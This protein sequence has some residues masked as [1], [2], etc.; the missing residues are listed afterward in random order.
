MQQGAVGGV[1]RLVAGLAYS[2]ASRSMRR[3]SISRRAAALRISQGRLRGMGLPASFEGMLL[4]LAIWPLS[5]TAL[6]R[7]AGV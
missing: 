1:V 5:V 4:Y 3:R 7:R 2:R 6:L